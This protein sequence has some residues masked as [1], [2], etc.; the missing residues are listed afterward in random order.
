M[1]WQAVGM[2]SQRLCS[3]R[4]HAIC[5]TSRHFFSMRQQALCKTS[6]RLCSRRRRDTSP[7]FPAAWSPLRRPPRAV[8]T[9]FSRAL[10]TAS[11]TSSREKSPGSRRFGE[12]AKVS[13]RSREKVTTWEWLRSASSSSPSSS[14]SRKAFQ[15]SGRGA[16]SG[17]PGMAA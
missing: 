12:A 7:H 6:R 16:A 11:R 3:I 8:A 14:A 5:M 1:K 2:T 15:A 13:G 10:H 17:T 9:G 4:Q